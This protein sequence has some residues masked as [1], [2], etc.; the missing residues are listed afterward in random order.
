[1]SRRWVLKF[2]QLKRSHY[3]P[4]GIPLISHLQSYPHF[5]GKIN[6]EFHKS[7][8]DPTKKIKHPVPLVKLMSQEFTVEI[9]KLQQGPPWGPK[10]ALAKI[11]TPRSW[12]ASSH[13]EGELEIK[14]GGMDGWM[15]R[16]MDVY[17]P[18]LDVRNHG[19]LA[20]ARSCWK[21]HLP[22]LNLWLFWCL[23]VYTFAGTK[24]ID[25]LA[26]IIPGSSIQDQVLPG[27]LQSLGK[28]GEL[29]TC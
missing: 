2:I 20:C 29:Q 21:I 1:M 12:P 23:D 18:V 6:C 7:S 14:D 9:P 28:S 15:D 25:S 11:P 3:I 26:M 19:F 10:A 24:C 8:H 13:L 16:W 5:L 17:K 22:D 4:I 27:V